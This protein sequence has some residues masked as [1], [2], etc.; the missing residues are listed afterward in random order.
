MNTTELYI[1]GSGAIGKALAVFLKRKGKN[2]KLVRGSVDRIPEIQNSIT[3]IGEKER[4]EQ[5]ITTTTFSHISTIDGIVLI[6]TKTFANAV[7]AKK[8][9]TLKGNFSIIL[10]QNG[11]HIERP[12]KTFPAV[13]RC[14]LFATSQVTGANEVTFKSVTASPVG[15]MEGNNEGLEQL[16]D[17][18]NTPQFAFRSEPDILKHIWNKTI[19]NCVFNTICPLLEIDNGIFHRNAMAEQMAVTVI[20]E[21]VAIAK[22]QGVLLDSGEVKEKLLL[23]SQKSDGQLISTYMDILNN[24]RTEIESLNLEIA[25]ISEELGQPELAKKTRVLGQL[26]QLKSTLAPLAKKV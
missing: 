21:C 12:F 22:L 4:F 26:I 8:L 20:E 11:L 25:R 3:V 13:F 2:V 9:S 6:T 17:Q 16:I 19:A 14:V 10:L 18:I 23:I 24:R 1:I 5:K 7:I 15:N